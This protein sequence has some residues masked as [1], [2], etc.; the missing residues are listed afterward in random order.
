MAK[1]TKRP[2]AKPAAKPAKTLTPIATVEEVP[3]PAPPVEAPRVPR[4]P[5]VSRSQAAAERLEDEYSYI[6]GDLRRVFLL[7][8]AMFALLIVVNL[9]FTMIG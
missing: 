6:T 7:A 3:A 9:V 1:K 2:Q 4:T 8:A 5:K